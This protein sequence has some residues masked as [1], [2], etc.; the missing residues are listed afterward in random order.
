MGWLIAL[1]AVVVAGIAWFVAQG[2]LGGMPPL[3]DDRPGPDLPDTDISGDDLREVRFA[4]T[5]RGYSMSQVDALLDRLADQL[6]GLP[7][8]PVDEYEAWETQGVPP[9]APA[10]PPVSPPE[11]V[12]PAP[13][14]AP[15]GTAETVP[16]E[17]A[18]AAPEGT[19]EAVPAE[20]KPA[21]PGAAAGDVPAADAT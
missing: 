14:A 10:G 15:E 5:L 2:R 3:V 7:Y 19:A 21:V 18:E 11:T 16:E 1:L 8:R 13:G 17:T 20:N 12:E 9:A 4:V 6:D